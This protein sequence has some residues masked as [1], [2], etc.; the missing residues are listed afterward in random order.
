MIKNTMSH[1]YAN[2]VTLNFEIT[3]IGEDE[4]IKL[5]DTLKPN[6]KVSGAHVN[7]LGRS[8]TDGNWRTDD[9][10][11]I[12]ID[13]NGA[14]IDGQHRLWAIIETGMRFDFLVVRGVGSETM[15][16]IDTGRQR[17]LVD[18]L[19]MNNEAEP[20]SL[21]GAIGL[22]TT[23]L[24]S[25]V[26][27][28]SGG[29]G[30][31]KYQVQHTIPEW[32]ATLDKHPKLRES[33][34]EGRSI[35][36]FIKGGGGRWSAIHYILNQIDRDDTQF[37]LD[38]LKTGADLHENDPIFALRTRLLRDAHTVTKKLDILDYTALVFKTWNA[39][40]QGKTIT[41]LGWRPGGA[42][43]ERYPMPE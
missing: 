34:T 14:L 16:I 11:P 3:E 2:G 22:Y 37:F 43:P 41:V 33:V 21:A 32:L 25:Q 7:A 20:V 23:W 36:R 12:R 28:R 29:R 1:T 5:L 39:F 4:A 26:L 15:Q 27:T 8:M 10:T 9:T 13:D 38:K 6:R 31:T 17:K 30:T 40:R 18:Y 42:H 35:A 19:R 24:R